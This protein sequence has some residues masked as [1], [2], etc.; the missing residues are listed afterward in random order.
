MKKLLI[1]LFLFFV[2]INACKKDDTTLAVK[3]SENPVSSLISESGWT[4]TSRSVSQYELGY[5]F[6]AIT[7]GKITQLGVQMGE[8]GTYTVSVWDATSKALLRQKSVEQSSPNKFSLATV[9]DLAIEKDKK[10]LVSVNNTSNS[11]KK[12]YNVL[13]KSSSTTI[14]PISKGS[15]VIQKSVYSSSNVTVFPTVDYSDSNAFYGFADF[16]FIPN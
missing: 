12:A 16:T 2:L 5:V 3:P 1:P 14:F 7:A 9:D 15:I 11:V 8:P 10:Y 6:S 13:G 4:L